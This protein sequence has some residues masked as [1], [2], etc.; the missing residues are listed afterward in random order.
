M[1]EA[2]ADAPPEPS[3][4]A[5]L[6]A[7]DDALVSIDDD[8]PTGT[9]EGHDIF[10]QVVLPQIGNKKAMRLAPGPAEQLVTKMFRS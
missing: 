3:A 6:L 1:V 7:V 9:L 4:D 5:S 2:I 10:F 8:D